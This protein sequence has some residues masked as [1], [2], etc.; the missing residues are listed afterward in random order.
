[1]SKNL[2]SHQCVLHTFFE[3]YT[4]HR[5]ILIRKKIGEL[6]AI[7][8]KFSSPIFMDTRKTHVYS[9]CTNC[10]LFA[11]FFLA[12]S[13]YCMFRQNFP[14]QIFNI[15][16]YGMCSLVPTDASFILSKPFFDRCKHGWNEI[17]TRQTDGQLYMIEKTSQRTILSCRWL[18]AQTT[19]LLACK[20]KLC[21]PILT[22]FIKHQSDKL[23]QKNELCQLITHTHMYITKV[24]QEV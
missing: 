17:L 19:C 5:K 12:N 22:H 18:Y 2:S 3:K 16:Q 1:M 9:L 20:I 23:I 24:Y 4:V 15:S 6:W 8:H 7:R 13:F 14:H 10:F 21:I 11:N